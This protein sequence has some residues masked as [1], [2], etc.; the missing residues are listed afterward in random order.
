MSIKVGKVKAFLL[1]AGRGSRLRP[2]TDT[3]PKCLVPIGGKTL[4]QRWLE[5]LH[6]AGINEA[7]INT[8]W[9]HQKVVRFAEKWD[10]SKVRLQTVFE[11]KLL[12]SAGTIVEN[13][14]WV[15]D[16]AEILIIYADNY[17]NMDL[18]DILNF[19]L[20]HDKEI[21]LGVFKSPVP[22]KCGI[23]EV[24]AS[25]EPVSFVEKPK[26]PQSDLAAAGLYLFSHRVVGTIAEMQRHAGIPYDLGFHV[27]P[28]LIRRSAIYVLKK[29]II[30]IGTPEAYEDLCES[31]PTDQ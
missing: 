20:N 8:H 27:F 25:G 14:G 4:L 24:G 29:P 11:P 21:T 1:A 12:G 9:L 31:I 7:L 23:I 17:P 19:H 15:E 6:E 30:D 28:K 26:F 3:V 5:A 10:H 16:A 22:E 18:G 13:A 2:I